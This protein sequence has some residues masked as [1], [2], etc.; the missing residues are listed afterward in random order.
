ME[1]DFEKLK[2]AIMSIASETFRFQSVFERVI[3]KL[4][5]DEQKKYGSQY[6][7]FSKKV[8]KALDDAG[9]HMINLEGQ[10]YDPGMMVAPLNLEDFE[11]NDVLFIE[12]MIEPIIMEEDTVLKEGTVILG[13]VK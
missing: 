10:V 7:W 8:N 3:G 12:K 2:S 13:R 11:T 1:K 9:M 4:D 5:I 6:A